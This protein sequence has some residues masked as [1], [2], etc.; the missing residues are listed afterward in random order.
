[1]NW[2][3]LIGNFLGLD[4]VQSI[5]RVGTSFAAPW[6]RGTGATWVLFGFLALLVLALWYYTRWQG[7][8][9][10]TVRWFLAIMRAVVLGIL[11]LLLAEP[12]LRIELTNVP[13]PLLWVLFDGTDSMAI[14]DEQTEDE[15]QKLAA[16]VSLDPAAIKAEQAKSKENPTTS[17]ADAVKPSRMEYVQAL[18]R[19]PADK[20]IINKLQEQYR[21]KALYSRSSRR[22]AAV[23][24]RRAVFRI[25]R[26][27]GTGQ[28]THDD[29]P[30]HGHRRGLED[31]A[32]RHS[33][34]NLAGL[35]IVSDFGQNAGIPPA[36]GNDTPAKR[37]QRPIYTI[38]IGPEST[39]DLGVDLQA[40]LVMKKNEEETLSVTLRHSALENRRVFV[41]VFGKRLRSG[42]AMT[43][44]ETFV[45]GQKEIELAGPTISETFSFK[46]TETGRFQFT[47]EVDPQ[48]G[49]VI[50]QNNR[51]EREVNIRDDFL[52]LMY[53][54]NEPSWEW[55]FVKEV[56]HRDKLV[57]LRGF[58]TFLNSADP[59]VRQ[60]NELF[61]PNL[62]PR[63]GD[64]FAN[65]VIFLG[66]M[67]ASVCSRPS[68]LAK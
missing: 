35:V 23:E 2:Q 5:D 30:S 40:P 54:E 20:N 57:G 1:M 3:Q 11:F 56:F 33:A 42:D 8:S 48:E 51:A 17:A 9:R 46:P 44:G 12:V 13:R 60:T 50:T 59:K 27:R 28:A 47:A 34:N 21:V 55:R 4:N 52:R 63:R 67:P 31:L 53:V 65:D 26:Y 37:L 32:L 61:L 25:D 62:T 24:C 64:F 7:T 14:R 39:V 6:A 18:L 49:E 58:R 36:G 16:A 43:E 38:G 68:A 19:Q 10:P 45:V 22:R 29:W 15:R 66:D 41:K